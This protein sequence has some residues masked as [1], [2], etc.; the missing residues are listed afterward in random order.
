M[1][2]LLLY[3]PPISVNTA[4]PSNIRGGRHLSKVG[5]EYKRMVAIEARNVWKEEPVTDLLR[6]AIW[7]SWKDKRRRDVPNF[8][9]VLIDALEG[10]VF[11]NDSQIID[12]HVIKQELGQTRTLLK[13]WKISSKEKQ[14]YSSDLDI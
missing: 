4:Y 3:D 12:L 6:M 7:F 1:F 11:L 10:I 8:Q 9:K 14:S 2:T 13:I 5:A